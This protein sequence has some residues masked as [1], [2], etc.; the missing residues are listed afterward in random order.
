MF[1]FLGQPNG[2]AKLL[3]MSSFDE[4]ENEKESKE[5]EEE[6]EIVEIHSS[7]APSRE[8]S[9]PYSV[10]HYPIEVEEQK[11]IIQQQIVMKEMEERASQIGEQPGICYGNYYEN[12]E[13]PF[14]LEELSLSHQLNIRRKQKTN[15]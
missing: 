2:Q 4:D 14:S 1:T 5:E 13:N 6:E 3:N 9:A 8:I 10:P 12:I 15:R 7:M 11:K